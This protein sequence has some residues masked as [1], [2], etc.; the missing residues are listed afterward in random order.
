METIGEI[1][2]RYRLERGLSKKQIA[3]ELHVSPNTVARWES[4][5]IPPT[6]EIISKLADVLDVGKE[7]LYPQNDAN[8][9]HS[10]EY[11]S[12]LDA[13]EEGIQAFST[14]VSEA[15]NCSTTEP[16][17]LLDKEMKKIRK[18]RDRIFFIYAV[19]AVAMILTYYLDWLFNSIF[20]PLNR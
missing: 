3:R 1:I 16:D 4:G 17:E 9:K 13:I 19:L 15:S 20:S 5:E 6:D 7:Q 18:K 8:E 14:E 12:V 11:E 2:R 10:E